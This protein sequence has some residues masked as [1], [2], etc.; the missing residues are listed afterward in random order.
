MAN[1]LLGLEVDGVAH[2]VKR[3]PL[4]L[5][6][7]SSD[8]LA[9]DADGEQL[10]TAE[11]QHRH[12]QRCPTLNNALASAELVGGEKYHQSQARHREEQPGMRRETQGL[13][14][15]SGDPVERKLHH[16]AQRVLGRAGI[17]AIAV[18]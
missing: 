10:H 15:E 8:V 14:R 11:E 7:D 16:L 4:D 12:C 2:E 6:V 17:P 3:T 1:L 5:F 18:I 9:E 13:A